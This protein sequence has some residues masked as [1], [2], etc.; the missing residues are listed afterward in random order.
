[1]LPRVFSLSDQIIGAIDEGQTDLVF[2]GVDVSL[3]TRSQEVGN[4]WTYPSLNSI[5][6]SAI[7]KGLVS[8][9][10]E[11]EGNEWHLSLNHTGTIPRGLAVNVQKG[12]S[13]NQFEL[14]D[15]FGGNYWY[16]TSYFASGKTG[17]FVS[18]TPEQRTA[19]ADAIKQAQGYF[20]GGTADKLTKSQLLDLYQDPDEER[21]FSYETGITLDSTKKAKRYMKRT[22][23]SAY[24]GFAIGDNDAFGFFDYYTNPNGSQYSHWIDPSSLRLVDSEDKPISIELFLDAA[25]A[26]GVLDASQ[27]VA[28]TDQFDQNST[29]GDV[30]WSQDNKPKS[31][32]GGGHAVTAIAWN[33]DYVQ[34][35]VNFLGELIKDLV[36]KSSKGEAT[37]REDIRAFINWAKAEG[38]AFTNSNQE[39]KGAWY[40]QNSWGKSNILDPGKEFQYLP[41]SMISGDQY[42]FHELDS[43]GVLGDV[44]SSAVIPPFKQVASIGTYSAVG[45]NFDNDGNDH[46]AALGLMSL[47]QAQKIGGM[48]QGS[49]Y[50]ADS[51]DGEPIAST[52]AQEQINGYQTLRFDESIHLDS[53][54]Q[55]VA[56]IEQADQGMKTENA[57]F[58]T[59]EINDPNLLRDASLSDFKPTQAEYFHDLPL[60]DLDLI[61][62]S[63]NASSGEESLAIAEDVYFAK[64]QD[65]QWVDVGASGHAF[66]LNVV[67]ENQ[68][69]IVSDAVD[70]ITGGF[71]SDR[72][73]LNDRG[74]TVFAGKGDDTVHVNATH[75]KI[76]LGS[77]DDVLI[78]T[79]A[80][81]SRLVVRGGK[82][83][84]T[85]VFAMGQGSHFLGEAKVNGFKPGDQVV[86][87]GFEDELSISVV[88]SRQVVV[89]TDEFSVKIKGGN[90]S[91]IGLID[92]VV[93]F[94]DAEVGL[95]F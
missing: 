37:P 69:N 26:A 67:Y 23:T 40:I 51:L 36:Q 16:A 55:Y 17:A 48:I 30:R 29:P 34:P 45:Y 56:V 38:Y 58:V 3:Q 9:P 76:R 82:G 81:G 60:K 18:Q 59:F 46:I 25:R 13:F 49:I 42:T 28:L 71:K 5:E 53:D 92:G 41:Y 86:F 7:A 52:D 6:T 12:S 61:Q 11:V 1:M 15:G 95:G 65:D 89:S 83:D 73:F 72:I 90:V 66:M 74:N 10:S 70:V 94:S 62:M 54:V 39:T 44:D 24:V 68:D 93:S 21:I 8:D 19:I 43:T 84:D 27:A 88:S 57:E 63:A 31:R 75:N 22:N 80:K 2:S 91:Q 85:Y 77:G 64:N 47:G 78:A 33:D 32:I 14:G 35:T 79:E 20:N 4:C 50:R 87:N